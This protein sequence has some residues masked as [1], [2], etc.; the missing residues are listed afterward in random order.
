[1]PHPFEL[2]GLPA[3][4]A[5]LTGRVSS[6]A[7]A[8]P[9]FVRN[10]R[11]VCEWADEANAAWSTHPLTLT[12]G[13]SMDRRFAGSLRA[14]TPR[15]VALS[16]SVN[17][18]VSA[19]HRGRIYKHRHMPQPFV[20]TEWHHS[21]VGAVGF[22]QS[23][24]RAAISGPSTSTRSIDLDRLAVNGQPD[25]PVIGALVTVI[26]PLGATIPVDGAGRQHQR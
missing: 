10:P 15:L 13:P 14:V 24:S 17:P 19:A 7:W 26:R 22:T 9:T 12:P 21:A 1:M 20:A 2:V 23:T 16:A 5:I 18:L 3:S 8:V 6:D 25:C 4:G 11:L